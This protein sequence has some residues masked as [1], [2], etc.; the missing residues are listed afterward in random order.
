MN[1]FEVLILI[2]IIYAVACYA[3]LFINSGLKL[4]YRKLKKESKKWTFRDAIRSWGFEDDDEMKTDKE[5]E[6]GITRYWERE[7]S[8]GFF[9]F[10]FFTSPFFFFYF[11]FMIFLRII[12]LPILYFL[13]EN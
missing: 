2:L 8:W 11:I 5:K 6:L 7:F 10:M 4:L 3:F 12:T 1:G 9:A 13:G